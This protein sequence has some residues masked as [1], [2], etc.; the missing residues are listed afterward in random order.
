MYIVQLFTPYVLLPSPRFFLN[1]PINDFTFSFLFETIQ[2][3]FVPVIYSF[4]KL[5]FGWFW[6][7]YFFIPWFILFNLDFPMFNRVATW[8]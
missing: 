7:F 6:P 3:S 5:L 1:I 2:K 4:L 8:T